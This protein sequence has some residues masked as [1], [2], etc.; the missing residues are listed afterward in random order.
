MMTRMVRTSQSSASQYMPTA[1]HHTWLAAIA[2]MSAAVHRRSR[3]LERII[4]P[5]RGGSPWGASSRMNT[6]LRLNSRYRH[7]ATARSA[8]PQ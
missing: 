1:Y 8:T 4:R 5:A 3:K 2:A 6:F 7:A